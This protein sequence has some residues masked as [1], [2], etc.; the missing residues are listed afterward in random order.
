[1]G[2]PVR[3][4]KDHHFKE[5]KGESDLIVQKALWARIARAF[6]GGHLIRRGKGTL[7]RGSQVPLAL[8][9]TDERGDWPGPSPKRRS[10][11]DQ[12]KPNKRTRRRA[13]RD[14]ELKIFRPRKKTKSCK[15]SSSERQRRFGGQSRKELD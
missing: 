9:T 8:L 11:R 5:A 10:P 6:E 15:N 13:H 12:R 7:L 2:N 3:G 1:V 14:Y 4:K